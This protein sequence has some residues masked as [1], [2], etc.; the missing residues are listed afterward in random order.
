VETGIKESMKI[1]FKDDSPEGKLLYHMFNKKKYKKDIVNFSAKLT[2]PVVA[3]G[4]PVQ[5]YF[6]ETINRLN[7]KLMI[8]DNADVANAVGTV[9]GNVEE[10]VQVL[11]K[12]AEGGA[13]YVYTPEGRKIFMELEEC[14]EFGEEYGRE[15][16]Y[17][18]AL[19]SGASNIELIVE[20]NERC[21]TLA[22][23]IADENNKIFI[24]TVIEVTA[25]GKPW[26]LRGH[27]T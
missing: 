10:R 11:V 22:G 27:Q 13:Y 3:L 6:P 7:T 26:R 14:Y 9:N 16:A 2:I 1:T 25:R 12:P 15:Y 23:N 4:A 8:P 5:A 17:N 18:K 24:E 19:E 20:R 21:S